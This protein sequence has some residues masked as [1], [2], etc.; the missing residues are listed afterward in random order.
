M[1]TAYSI[2]LY[3]FLTYIGQLYGCVFVNMPLFV[4]VV[5]LALKSRAGNIPHGDITTRKCHI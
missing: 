2:F 1:C 5:S 3:A 4:L